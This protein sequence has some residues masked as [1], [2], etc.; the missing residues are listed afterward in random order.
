MFNTHQVGPH[1]LTNVLTKLIYV[2]DIHYLCTWEV[3]NSLVNLQ[4][5]IFQIGWHS[6]ANNT[7]ET[8]HLASH[9]A[10]LWQNLR[11][12][13]RSQTSTMSFSRQ[14]DVIHNISH[15]EIEKAILNVAC[16]RATARRN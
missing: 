2:S 9:V 7:W 15:E 1:H 3:H 13:S 8:S 12:T 6:L 11:T 14:V 16:S 10:S 4:R 5:L